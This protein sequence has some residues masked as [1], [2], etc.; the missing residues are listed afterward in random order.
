MKIECFV[1]VYLYS[2][3][4]QCNLPVSSTTLVEVA[5]FVVAAV[6]KVAAMLLGVDVSTLLG[7]VVVVVV[8]FVI[9]VGADSKDAPFNEPELVPD[10]L[11]FRVVD[12][13]FSSVT[14]KKLKLSYVN[15]WLSLSSSLLLF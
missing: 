1:L 8:V 13:G 14:E 3:C 5:V 4:M 12:V 6:V 9:D 11:L 10:G 2:L 15:L 7:A